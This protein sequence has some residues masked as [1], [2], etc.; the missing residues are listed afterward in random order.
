MKVFGITGG[1]GAGKSTVVE[2]WHKFG[3][4]V[5]NCDDIYHALL[6]QNDALLREIEE[7]FPGVVAQGRLDRRKL[8]GLVFSNPAGLT[9]LNK[10]THKYVV[11]KV[12]A[13][14]A[15]ARREDADVAV[16][17]ALY[18]LETDLSSMCDM[19]VGVTA[20]VPKRVRRIVERDGISEEYAWARLR[21]QKDDEYFFQNC[22]IVIEN[23]GT[24]EQLKQR[25]RDVYVEHR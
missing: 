10:I 24:P 14:L 1:T 2:V 19:I 7:A 3:A 17:E 8:G 13:E 6:Q 16:I 20:P 22:D 5:L 21:A 9:R 11:E 23:S 25:A 12:R 15:D 4:R 18:L